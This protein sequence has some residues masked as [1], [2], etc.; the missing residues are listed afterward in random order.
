MEDEHYLTPEQAQDARSRPLVLQGQ[1]TPDRSVAPYFVED[2]RKSLEQKYGAKA[3]YEKGLRVQTT[4]DADLQEVANIAVERGLR[5][6]DKRR[7]GYRKVARN[8]IADGQPIERF[9]TDRWTKPILAGGRPVHD[10][11]SH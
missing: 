4:L 2:I 1:P 5:K 7:S 8:V 6:L 9:M 11:R 10:R 3:L